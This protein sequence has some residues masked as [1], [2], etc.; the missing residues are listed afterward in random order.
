MRDERYRKYAELKRIEDLKKAV[1]AEEIRLSNERVEIYNKRKNEELRIKREGILN[2]GANQINQNE[3]KILKTF[4][5]R[6]LLLT[7]YFQSRIKS[8]R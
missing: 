7:E 8:L 4:L 3:G 2:I 6:L 5:L 1:T